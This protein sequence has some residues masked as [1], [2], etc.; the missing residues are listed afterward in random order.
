MRNKIDGVLEKI[1]LIVVGIM[2]VSVIWQVVS[3]Y[4]LGSPSTLTDEIASFSLIWLG[5]YGAAY[6]T[7]K[8]LHLSIDVIS[9]ATVKKYPQLF[10]GIVT[11]AVVVFALAVMVIGGINLCWVTFE[12]QQQ[13]AA[14]KIPLFWIYSAVPFSGALIV[15]YSLHTFLQGFKNQKRA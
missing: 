12:L 15:Y 8:H 6:A 1:L 3:R 10:M 4:L 2:L 5:L 14:L 9:A 7:G 13:S 11:L